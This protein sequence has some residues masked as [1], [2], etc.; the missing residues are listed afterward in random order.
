MADGWLLRWQ[1]GSLAGRV[2]SLVGVPSLLPSRVKIELKSDKEAS[3]VIESSPCLVSVYLRVLLLLL[4]IH[5]GSNF[6]L[7]H[8]CP[9]GVEPLWNRVPRM[10]TGSE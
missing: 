2:L 8:C 1:R 4:E 3:A 10:Q 9:L 5:Q 7:N 6:V